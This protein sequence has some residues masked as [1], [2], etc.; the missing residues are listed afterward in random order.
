MG[1]KWLIRTQKQGCFR[2]PSIRGVLE[3]ECVDLSGMQRISSIEIKTAEVSANLKRGDAGE[4][5][6]TKTFCNSVYMWL[7][8]ISGK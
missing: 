7:R 4:S 3:A 2:V 8:I 1:G 5:S 6:S